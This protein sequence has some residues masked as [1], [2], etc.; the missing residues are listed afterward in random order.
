MKLTLLS[1]LAILSFIA[2]SQSDKLTLKS[3]WTI[4]S[5][6]KITADG[7]SIS[8]PGYQPE[9]WYPVT[10]PSTVLAG[11][12][13]NKV[14]PDP[15]YGTNIESL[16]GYYRGVKGEMPEKSPFRVPWWYRTVFKLPADYKGK[17]AWLKLQGIN[18]QANIWL[19]GHLIADTT[20]IEGVYRLFN[21]DI[22]RYAVPGSDNCLAF[23]IYPPRGQDLTITLVDWNPTPPDRAMGIW[24]DMAVVSSGQVAIENPR[25]ITDLDLPSLD[26]AKLTVSTDLHNSVTKPVTG[27]LKG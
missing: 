3:N 12:V 10:M 13:A 8:Q 15:Y 25:V 11:L 21:L 18:Y 6:S 22:S 9:N 7:K 1:A 5:S 19:N 4:Q 16:P 23:E 17:H 27:I 2:H 26:V 14:F 24:Y 20:A